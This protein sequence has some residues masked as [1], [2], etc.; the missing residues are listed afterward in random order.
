[1][2]KIGVLAKLTGSSIKSLRYYDKID[3]LKPIYID[4]YTKY[5]YYD[6]NSIKRYYLI[7]QLKEMGFSLQEI[8]ENINYL[9]DQKLLQKKEEHLDNINLLKRKIRA[10]DHM[11]LKFN[12]GQFILGVKELSFKIKTQ[13]NKSKKIRKDEKK[14]ERRIK[15][16]FNF[17]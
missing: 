13:N 2:Y 14:Y 12:N 4:Y 7:Q 11:R 15:K 5:R 1:M 3:L 17:N 8:K 6:D 16:V 10:I 9:T